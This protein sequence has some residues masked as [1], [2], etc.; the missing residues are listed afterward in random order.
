MTDAAVPVSPPSA[1][2][3]S[4]ITALLRHG[5]YV[6]AENKVTGF[7]FGLFIAIVLAALIGPYLVPYDPLASDTAA[8]LKGPSLA[9]GS[10]GTT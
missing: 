3:P 10:Y 1:S 4:G 7:A 6:I 2:P 5:R 9:S 8:A